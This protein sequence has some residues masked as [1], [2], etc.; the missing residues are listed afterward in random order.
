MI[1]TAF[2]FIMDKNSIELFINDGK[3][4]FSTAIYTPLSADG[5]ALYSDDNVRM[6]ICKYEL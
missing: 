2:R 5:I 6:N 3:M 1:P 4:V